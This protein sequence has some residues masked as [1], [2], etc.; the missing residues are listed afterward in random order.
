MRPAVRTGACGTCCLT[1]C[2]VWVFGYLN[3]DTQC[4]SA[5]P[6][7][8]IIGVTVET[9]FRARQ[10]HRLELTQR[11]GRTAGPWLFGG[12][13]P[14]STEKQ[15]AGCGRPG[16]KWKIVCVRNPGSRNSPYT[17]NA[18]RRDENRA[19]SSRWYAF[20]TVVLWSSAFVF[21]KVALLS[22]FVNRARVPA[23][24][25][26]VPWCSMPCCAAR[27][28]MLSWRELPPFTLSGALGFSI[29]LFIFNKGSET[30]TAATGCILIATAPIITA[31]MASAVF[32]ERLT[33]LAWIA[34]MACV[35]RV[36][37]LMLWNGAFQST[38]GYSGCSGPPLPSVRTT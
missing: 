10:A 32:R 3:W 34:H 18:R 29:Y 5:I 16:G 37:V 24:R 21:T 11:F 9:R 22:F 23:L 30:L 12:P 2:P 13:P 17:P 27:V 31:L 6:S 36:L 14:F 20:A 8:S 38:P 1:S 35:P 7:T 19:V 15:R 25:H 33:Q 28:R 26:R 4:C